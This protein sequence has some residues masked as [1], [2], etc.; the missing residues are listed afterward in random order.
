MVRFDDTP[1]VARSGSFAKAGRAFPSC[2]SRAAVG[3]SPGYRDPVE[4][5]LPSIG[6]TGTDR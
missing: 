2:P 4:R 3:I 1:K 5:M 6:I